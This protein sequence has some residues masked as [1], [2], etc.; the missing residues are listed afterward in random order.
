MIKREDLFFFARIKDVETFFLSILESD[1]K[2]IEN[3]HVIY[4]DHG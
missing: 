2:W 1:I 4:K 3:D